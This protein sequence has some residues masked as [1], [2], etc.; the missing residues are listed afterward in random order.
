MYLMNERLVCRGTLIPFENSEEN[1][2][3]VRVAISHGKNYK[4][5]A[6]SN[7]ALRQSEQ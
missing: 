2:S 1:K 4:A 5:D 6:L 3:L 7:L